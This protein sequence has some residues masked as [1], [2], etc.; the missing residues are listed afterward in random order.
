[1]NT[2]THAARHGNLEDVKR[3][4][5]DISCVD[6]KDSEGYTPLHWSS[7][8]GHYDIVEHLLD[9]GADMEER[10]ADWNTTALIRACS[11]GGH[12][13][14]AKLLLDRGANIH[15]V[16]KN[17]AGSLHH[18][19]YFGHDTVVELL[20]TR[21]AN[22]N[23]CD[24]FH[25]T[26]LHSACVKGHIKCVKELLRHG[27]DVN[28]KTDKGQTPLD[29]AREYGQTSLAQFLEE[30][31][32]SPPNQVD[33]ASDEC[34]SAIDFN[35]CKSQVSLSDI[36]EVDIHQSN[37]DQ[38]ITMSI[39][40]DKSSVLEEMIKEVVKEQCNECFKEMKASLLKFNE[41]VSSGVARVSV[42]HGHL[43]VNRANRADN[44]NTVEEEDSVSKMQGASDDKYHQ[45]IS[46]LA[47]IQND[48]H[49]KA[50][51]KRKAVDNDMNEPSNKRQKFEDEMCSLDEEVEKS[52]L[53]MVRQSILESQ[54]ACEQSI[55]KMKWDILIAIGGL[56]ALTMFLFR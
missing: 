25:Q 45:K 44:G 13:S 15:S 23:A 9:R 12:V 37:E 49:S 4:L 20:L 42:F 52:V 31:M 8:N 36:R 47:I 50:S 32:K 18:A 27:V 46:K 3:L 14:I 33:T 29:W 5:H 17:G 28:A 41:G 2:L 55:K 38:K 26:P 1:M 10:T 11:D 30:H 6:V 53:E 7:F 43:R 22:A 54:K 51:Q 39:S 19:S 35:S 24:N 34:S 16:N 40:S 21:G 56:N 48:D